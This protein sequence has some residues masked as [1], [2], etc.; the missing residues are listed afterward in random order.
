MGA[1]A[2]VDEVVAGASRGRSRRRADVAVSAH[3]A[4]TGA[5]AFGLQPVVAVARGR[6]L[7]CS[8]SLDYLALVRLVGKKIEA[9][10]DRML[11]ADE[12]LVFGHDLAHGRFDA[13]KVVFAKAG[14]TGQLE[15]VIE[16]V[17]DG[18]ADGVARPGPEACDRLSHDV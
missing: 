1:T 15:V 5:L 16:A 9:L 12:L 6:L 7:R 11:L 8:G 3:P 13:G 17:F 18:R 10:V 14:A 2:E 4:S